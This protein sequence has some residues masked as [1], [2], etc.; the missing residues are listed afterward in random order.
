M[1]SDY[2]V[3]SVT[4]ILYLFFSIRDE[5]QSIEIITEIYFCFILFTGLVLIV[6]CLA[7]FLVGGLLLIGLAPIIEFLD[8]VLQYGLL[9]FAI[10]KV[11]FRYIYHFFYLNFYFW[12][13]K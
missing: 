12:L 6:S 13:L 9:K 4:T 5:R 1:R 10:V 8:L 3:E 2:L 11:E 7:S